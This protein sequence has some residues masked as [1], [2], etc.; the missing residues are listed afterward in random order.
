MDT[1]LASFE[2][3]LAEVDVYLDFLKS[4]E[5]TAQ[6][7]PPRLDGA[8][9]PITTAQ[10]KILFSTVY[11]Q[12]YNL[13]ES[14]MTRCIDA[15]AKATMTGSRWRPADLSLHLRKEWVRAKARPY[16]ELNAEHRFT[17]AVEVCNHLVA[18]LPVVEFEI[19]KGGG[20]NWD[21]TAIE[22]VCQR[23]GLAINAP[24]DVYSAVKRRFQDDMGPLTL[25]KVLRN[26]LAHGSISFVEC[27]ETTTVARLVE[28]RDMTAAYLRQ[29]VS[30]FDSFITGYE[31]V[32]EDRRPA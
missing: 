13:V 10:Q 29:V 25:V 31:F 20:G 22:S 5:A 21:D 7:G 23:L 14:S 6:A 11:L 17:T 27:A 18:A 16:V 28:L 30:R 9:Q 3:R 26:R 32:A 24:A 4:I 19:E 12:L 1:L 8:D 15:V 2:E